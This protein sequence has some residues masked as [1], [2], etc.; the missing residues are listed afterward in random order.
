VDAF[1]MKVAQSGCISDEGCTK[2][3]LM[4]VDAFWWRLHRVDAFLMKVA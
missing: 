1:L 2:W 4:K 3:I